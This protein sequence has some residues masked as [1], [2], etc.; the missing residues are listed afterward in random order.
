MMKITVI[1]TTYNRPDALKRVLDGLLAQTCLPDEIIVAD[2]GSTL[3]TRAML[4]PYIALQGRSISHVWQKDKGFRAGR[5]RN[6][7]VLASNGDYLI[8]LDGDCIP[9]AHFVADHMSLAEKGCFFQGKRVLVHEKQTDSFDHRDSQ[10]ILRLIGLALCSSISNTHHIIRLPFFPSY[11]VEKIS[12]IRSCNMGI[13]KKDLEAINGFNQAFVGWGREDTEFVVRLFKY[14][15][16]RKENPFRA[17]CYHLWHPENSRANL[18][19]NDRL[20]EAS[21][22]LDSYYCDSGLSSLNLDQDG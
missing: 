11:K 14:G 19:E 21:V 9:E 17:I 15:L 12:G 13:Y 22:K 7:A 20:L 6:K 8:L 3:D 4:A 18:A 10:S 16:K 5:I 2:D 1:V